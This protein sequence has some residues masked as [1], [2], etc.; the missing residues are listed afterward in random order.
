MIEV[1]DKHIAPVSQTLQNPFPG[2]RPFG[3]EESHLFFGREGQSEEVVEMLAKHR[4]STVIG[5][6]GSGKSSLMYCGILPVLYGG[7]IADVGSSWH[8]VISRPGSS[9]IDNL[10]EAIVNSL[11]DVS[12][13]ITLQKQIT[14]TVLR[15][16]SLG[17]IEAVKQ[18][19]RPKNENILIVIDQF[20]ELFRFQKQTNNKN[21]E[22]ETLA[23]I[24]LIVNAIEQSELPI[25]IILTMRSDFIGDCAQ[26]PDL[27]SK[28]N[29]SHYLVPQMTRE[30]LRDAIAG[31]VAVGGG[32]IT[33]RLVEELLN[34]VGDNPDQLPIL[35]HALM[36]TWE[37][38]VANK[39]PEEGMDLKHYDAVGRM[40]QALSMHANEAYDELTQE[41]KTLCERVFKTLTEK[42]ADN[43]GIRN[44]SP[45]GEVAN[46][47]GVSLLGVT[48]VVD[49]FRLHGRSFISPSIDKSVQQETILDISHESLMRVW[50]RLHSWVD[51]EASSIQMYMRLSEAAEAYQVGKSG[52]WRPPDLQLALAWKEKH[53]PNLPWAERYDP[54]FE[55]AL[56]FLDTSEKEYKEEEENKIRL[57]KRT[58]KRTKIFAVIL[59]LFTILS[60][61]L[62]L[63]AFTQKQE[64]DK[65][66]LL[67]QE[68]TAD[69]KKERDAAELAKQ[70]ALTQK[71]LA[72]VAEQDALAQKEKANAALANAKEQERLANIQKA[73]AERLLIVAN[74]EKQNARDALDKAKEQTR[75]ATLASAI[76]ENQKEKA[77]EAEKKAL[78]L[79]M[80]SIANAMAVK[81]Q[82]INRDTLKRG[83]IAFQAYQFNKEHGGKQYNP[84]IY[85]GMYY[86]LKLMKEEEY[87]SLI[88]HKEAV[89]DMQY[90]SV[91]HQLYSVGSDGEIIRWQNDTAEVL[92]ET[93]VLF[94]SMKINQTNTHLAA[95]TNGSQIYLLKL[96]DGNKAIKLDAH[97]GIVWD[98]AFS[99]DQKL[100]SLGRDQNINVWDIYSDSIQQTFKTEAP[101]RAFDIDEQHNLIVGASLDGQIITWDLEGGNRTIMSTGGDAYY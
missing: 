39:A 71:E 98:L 31:P 30:N 55:R 91:D 7:F 58:L 14:S 80:L 17:L 87:N 46:I 11:K 26:F 70:D 28:I 21:V 52:L 63:W 24:R 34:G 50:N 2:L 76:A 65:Q 62:M 95:S 13:S 37:Y 69:A 90:G 51:D 96:I 45:A 20:E 74:S 44:P 78:N 92:L 99:N 97:R 27:T 36:R 75:R 8:T 29:K 49:K 38:W 66:F 47:S 16:S 88:G 10:S 86:A 61:G 48:E 57:Q 6:S 43:R 53:K 59:A 83:L 89:R 1:A 72:L 54:A 33:T 41:Q 42:G 84:D 15:G 56:V 101:I 93:S 73:R 82:Q 68:A 77:K 100:Y 12:E 35:Q 18:I 5:A 60:F 32:Q 19:K 40:E 3:T 79:R 25:Y 94:R 81:S 23:F 64:A 85:N 9:P 4:F 67:A 22:N